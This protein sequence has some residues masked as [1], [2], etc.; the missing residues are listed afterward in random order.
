MLTRIVSKRVSQALLFIV[1]MC[2]PTI[3]AAAQAGIF[4]IQPLERVWSST[5]PKVSA[6]T[7]WTDP[8]CD[9]DPS[10]VDYIF[11]FTFP[12]AVTNPNGVRSFSH[13]LA[14]DAMLLWYQAQYG[15]INGSGNTGSP[16]VF[17]CLGD[18]GVNMA[19]GPTNVYYNLKLVR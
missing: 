4:W 13:N 14:V 10:D 17:V 1:V 6:S 8:L 3:V 2:I 18:N 7:W 19:G 9:E 11:A 12:S 5:A 16:N 15:G